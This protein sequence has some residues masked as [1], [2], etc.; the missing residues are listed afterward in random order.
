MSASAKKTEQQKEAVGNSWMITFADLLS[1]LL[2]FFVLLFSMSTVQYDS[3]KA[4][5]N[6]M[7]DEFNPKRPQIDVSPH[8]MPDHLKTKA[9]SGLNLNYLQA[10]MER[11]ISNQAALEGS[12]VQLVG[13]K[14][15]ISVP[16]DLLFERK[17]AQLV[18]GATKPLKALAGALAQIQNKI[19]I[20]G[21]T[22]PGPVTN[23]RYRSNWELSMARAR[24][25]A[26]ILTDFGY[27]QSITVLGHADTVGLPNGIAVQRARNLAERVDIVIIA[28]RR[29]KGPYDLF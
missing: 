27:R 10:L 12:L 11:A 25:V 16:A 2:T 3:W 28:D 6:T 29:E 24:I 18:T 26:G 15:V 5:V 4:V 22:D 21:H 1:L 8:E 9:A 20:E 7:S 14:V 13:D 23:G 17:D 19:R